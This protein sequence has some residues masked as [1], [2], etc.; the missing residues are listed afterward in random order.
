MP[1]IP[2]V[3][4]EAK[5]VILHFRPFFWTNK[6]FLNIYGWTQGL[7]IMLLFAV[8]PETWTFVLIS[9]MNIRVDQLYEEEKRE[10]EESLTVYCKP[11]EL[12]NIL[13]SRATKN[14]L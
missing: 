13:Q 2:L 9:Y 11:I 3:S 12:Y 1:G 14:V 5:Y 7:R 6:Q 10:H 4:R 8:T